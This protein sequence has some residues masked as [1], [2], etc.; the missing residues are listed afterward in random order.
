MIGNI[1]Q[2]WLLTFVLITKFHALLCS[3]KPPASSAFPFWFSMQTCKEFNLARPICITA[4]PRMFDLIIR[5]RIKQRCQEIKEI[6]FTD[7]PLMDPKNRNKLKSI[8]QGC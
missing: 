2:T 6:N 5:S 7:G 4:E 8:F 3:F 1:K